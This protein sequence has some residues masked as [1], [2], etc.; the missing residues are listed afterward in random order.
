MAVETAIL[1]VNSR[2]QRRGQDATFCSALRKTVAAIGHAAPSLSLRRSGLPHQLN[3]LCEV[4]P[5][6][7]LLSERRARVEKRRQCARQSVTSHI[8]GARVFAMRNHRCIRIS[9]NQGV[10]DARNSANLLRQTRLQ[11]LF[12]RHSKWLDSLEKFRGSGLLFGL[13]S[14][15]SAAPEQQRCPNTVAQP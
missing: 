14:L 6:C 11:I 12:F 9:A 13:T 8:S 4:T 15:W 5:L 3:S 1:A 2:V 7:R 10:T